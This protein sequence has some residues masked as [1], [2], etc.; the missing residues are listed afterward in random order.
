MLHWRFANYI[1]AAEML[2][3]HLI[4]MISK[5]FSSRCSQLVSAVQLLTTVSKVSANRVDGS[6]ERMA[7]VNLNA[8]F[9][10]L[11]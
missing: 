4:E 3:N 9:Q 11:R 2:Q 5:L 10:H 6:M 1:V 8:V 7:I